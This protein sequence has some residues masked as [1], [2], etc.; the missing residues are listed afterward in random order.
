MGAWVGEA[1]WKQRAEVFQNPFT[2]R[3]LGRRGRFGT[4][5]G[6]VVGKTG[7]RKGADGH[8]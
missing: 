1:P 5:H 4:S 6:V 2:H 7:P 3:D 8:I